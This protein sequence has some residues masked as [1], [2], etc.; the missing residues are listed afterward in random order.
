[1]SKKRFQLQESAY[2]ASDRTR[3][4]VAE[5]D[6]PDHIITEADR[7][8][9]ELWA[10]EM[11]VLSKYFSRSRECRPE[12]ALR[13]L[14][15][16]SRLSRIEPSALPAP[17]QP[18]GPLSE[19]CTCVRENAGQLIE[20]VE[21]IAAEHALGWLER[22]GGLKESYLD[23]IGISSKQQQRFATSLLHDL[24][25]LE[26]ARHTAE[27]LNDPRSSL[28]DSV[29]KCRYWLTENA[30]AF[31]ACGTL[32]A[33]ELRIMRHDLPAI[34]RRLCETIDKYL[35]IRSAMEE[36]DRDLS[37]AS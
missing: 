28:T 24:D 23:A 30:H 3:L 9:V 12:A 37:F 11:V 22:A 15:L 4:S 27:T 33:T 21:L 16:W 7:T 1:M 29:M 20:A 31:L 34:D 35:S 14:A 26:L 18:G 36:M 17:N 5:H 6:R 8:Q 25:D 32:I 19:A 2:C 10:A 13:L